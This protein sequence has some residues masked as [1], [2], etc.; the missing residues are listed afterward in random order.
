MRVFNCKHNDY[1]PFFHVDFA[2][3][4]ISVKTWKGTAK[5]M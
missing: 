3:G 4:E 2:I 1:I 5:Q